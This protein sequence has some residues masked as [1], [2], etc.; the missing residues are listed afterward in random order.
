MLVID[1]LASWLKVRNELAC[2]W[3]F[4]AKAVLG[5]I[6]TVCDN[7]PQGFRSST[8]PFDC[9]VLRSCLVSQRS[10]PPHRPHHQ[11]RL[12]NCDWMPASYTSGQPP[13]LRRHPTCW[14]SS[15]RS[16]TVSRTPCNGAWTSAPL[17]A[18]PSI[19]CCCTE[20]QIETPM[21]DFS[22]PACTNGVWPPLQPV[23]V[24]QNKPSTMP[25]FT[26]QSIDPP[27]DYTTWRFWTMRQPNGCSTPARYLGGLA[28]DKRT[29]SNERRRCPWLLRA[30]TRLNKSWHTAL[31]RGIREPWA[32]GG[33]NFQFARIFAPLWGNTNRRILQGGGS[34]SETCPTISGSFSWIF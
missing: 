17:S 32:L 10:H 4:E 18:H 13:N 31:T 29:R 15:Q 1:G 6:V 27:T 14:A 11:R 20:P 23:S 16:H 26:V 8:G 19:E 2:M 9:R 22:A 12:A 24:A 28:V 3:N 25:S 7:L 5:Y 34:V 33:Q 21:L 30:A